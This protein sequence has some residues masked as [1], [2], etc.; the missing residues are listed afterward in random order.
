MLPPIL[1]QKPAD[2]DENIKSHIKLRIY[3]I[4]EESILN[5]TVSSLGFELNVLDL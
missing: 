3:R 2:E 1:G 5:K 4:S